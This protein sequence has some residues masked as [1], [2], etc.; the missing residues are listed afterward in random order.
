MPPAGVASVADPLETVIPLLRPQVVLSKVVSGAGD[1]SIRKPRYADPS[2]C[3]MLAGNCWL[4]PDGIDPVELFAGDF[5]LLPETPSFV[6]ASDPSLAPTDVELHP[7]AD[8]HYGPVDGPEPMR[9]L[10][11]YFRFDRANA[12]LLVKLLPP[13][14]LIR[15]DESGSAR[16]N[17]IVE[18]IT[19][20][21]IAQRPCREPILERLVEVLLIEACRFR[22]ERPT[23]GENGLIAGLSDPQLAGALR[24]I[25]D[26][27]AEHWTVEKLARTANM[28][29]AV[30]AERFANTIGMPP[31]QYVLEWRVALAKDMLQS[32]QLSIGEIAART[33]YRSASAFTTAFTRV[34]GRSPR[35]YARGSGD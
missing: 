29:R 24:E 4:S 10:G 9:M 21:A 18:L 26:G 7:S 14:I 15:H 31:M 33:G 20:E 8:S 25:H 28:S 34:T 23:V 30:F 17:R 6:M 35:A 11:G 13:T 5:L 32:E 1:W 12:R 27:V 2:F 22:T 3:L 16:L 19:D